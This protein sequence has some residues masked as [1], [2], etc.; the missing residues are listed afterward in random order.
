MEDIPI[1][2]LLVALVVL[3]AISAFFSTSETSMMALNRY[4]LKHLT[5]QGHRGA[6]LTSQ[7]LAHTDKLL[8]VVLLG[9]NLANAAAAALVTVIS[10]R[11]FEQSELVLSIATLLVTFAILVFSEVT[12]KILGA[13]YPER[14]ALPASY[15]LTPLLK[16]FQPAVW[17]I[18]LFVRALLWLMRLRPGAVENENVLGVEELR[19]LVTESAKFMPQKHRSILLNLFELEHIT[20]NDTMTPR[21]Q[22]EAIDIEAS[23]D[24]IL[25]QLATS[26]HTRLPVYQGHLDDIIGIIHVRHVLHYARGNALSPDKLREIM[27]EAYFIPAGTP[28]FTQLQHFQESQRRIGL[29][30]DEYGELMGLVTLEEIL[31]EIVGEFTTQAP[32]QLSTYRKQDDGSWLVEGSSLVRDLN[33]KL[34]FKLPVDGPKTLNGLILEYLEDMPE[35]GT[36]LKIADHPLEII[37]VQERLVKVVCIFPALI[38]DS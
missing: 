17:F 19:T 32:S 36:S 24:T 6:R 1:S 7:L 2:A 34:G 21:N 18:N 23:M 28:L 3:L 22:I 37:Q 33:R 15:V 31:E 12:P 5:K 27:L 25:E 13:A 38:T 10:F 4:R 29:V 30:V 11:L 14:I 9:N 16:L 8:G 35:A 20:V 26:H